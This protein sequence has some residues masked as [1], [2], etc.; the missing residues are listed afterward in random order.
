MPAAGYRDPEGPPDPS[1][2][3]TSAHPRSRPAPTVGAGVTGG[4]PDDGFLP[5]GTH[6]SGDTVVGHFVNG[7]ANHCGSQAMQRTLAGGFD[8]AAR[9]DVPSAWQGGGN[10]RCPLVPRP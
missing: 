7:D 10:L 4:V 9:Q 3:G 2:D 5:R 1:T 8:M 6:R